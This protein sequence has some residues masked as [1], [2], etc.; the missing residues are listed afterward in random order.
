[1]KIRSTLSLIVASVMM[2]GAA[3]AVPPGSGPVDGPDCYNQTTRD[4]NAKYPN[5]NSDSA[6]RAAY[7]ACINAG[8][9]K[10]DDQFPL[11]MRAPVGGKIVVGTVGVFQ[12]KT[13]VTKPGLVAR[14]PL[15]QVFIRR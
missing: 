15:N 14:A 8:L 9:D 6:T 5:P 11:L 1:M 2:V 7:D 3:H 13:P 10:C 4:C 12:P